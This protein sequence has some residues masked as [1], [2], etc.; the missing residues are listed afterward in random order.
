MKFLYVFG[1]G[2]APK[3]SACANSAVGGSPR[4]MRGIV[5]LALISVTLG[6]S[7][8]VGPPEWLDEL[9]EELESEPVANP[10]LSITRYDYQGQVVYF[11]PPR[12]VDLF[13]DLYDADGNVICHPDGGISGS[14]DGRCPTF[15]EERT[16]GTVIWHQ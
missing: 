14:G 13:S 4:W 5:A 7:D 1:T 2:L 12:D 3:V 9:I 15:F 16:N 8:S 11:L 6:C 10:E